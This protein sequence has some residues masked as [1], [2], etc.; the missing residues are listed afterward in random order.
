MK[1]YRLILLHVVVLM[2][3]AVLTLKFTEEIQVLKKTVKAAVTHRIEATQSDGS[4]LADVEPAVNNADAWYNKCRIIY[5]AGGG[6]NGHTYTNSAE[7]V[8]KTLAENPGVCFIEMDFRMTSDNVLVCVHEWSDACLNQTKAPSLQE[9]LS[10]KIQ[11]EYSPLT[12]EDF[13]RIMAENADLYLITDFKGTSEHPLP[14]MAAELVRLS[15][16]DE[17]ILNRVI[18]EL[19][20][21]NDKEEILKIYPFDDDQFIFSPYA[22]GG[23]RPEIASL[24]SR[25]NITV[26]ATDR[27]EIPDDE[28]A[29]LRELG[30]VVYEFTVNRLD[31]ARIRMEQGVCGFYT[32]YLTPEDLL[33]P[34]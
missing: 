31:E 7:A 21:E 14:E 29:A 12:A 6:I 8:E 28:L 23:W 3:L 1:K 4:L 20:G 33:P 10:W 30:Y 11:G 17:S 34:S 18:I 2:L 9:F 25:Q 27:Y 24:C 32:D 19:H 15:G 26:I 13:L 22:I 16:R 5:H